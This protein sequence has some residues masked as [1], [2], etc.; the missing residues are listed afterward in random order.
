M[1]C[2]R[3]KGKRKEKKRKLFNTKNNNNN[4][5]AARITVQYS[6]SATYKQYIPNARQLSNR[7]VVRQE[8]RNTANDL[9]VVQAV[10]RRSGD[11]NNPAEVNLVPV[12]Q[13]LHLALT[14]HVHHLFTQGDGRRDS[15][16][17][18]TSAR[19]RRNKA[20]PET[21]RDEQEASSAGS[22]VSKKSQRYFRALAPPKHEH[23]KK[24]TNEATAL[25]TAFV[26][27]Q[28]GAAEG[29][30]GCAQSLARL[31]LETTEHN[32][33]QPHESRLINGEAG[34][35]GRGGGLQTSRATQ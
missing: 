16:S 13:P 14:H 22:A 3:K 18:S 9:F 29:E 31:S 21:R 12:L 19:G 6:T 5:L 2:R 33:R 10:G 11:T 35:G 8:N 28:I 24:R 32:R 17:T 23:K 7:E 25:A 30:M 34:R 20:T 27:E 26:R 1:F 4:N 15:T